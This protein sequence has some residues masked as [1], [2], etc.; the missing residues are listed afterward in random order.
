MK[1]NLVWF[2]TLFIATCS[3]DVFAQGTIIF[4]N[5]ITGA[6]VAPVYGPEPSGLPL[7]GNSPSGTPPGTTIYT[8]Q[9]LSG[10]GFTAQLWAGPDINSLEPTSPGKPFATGNG[11]GFYPNSTETVL[12]VPALGTAQLQ[13]RAWDNEGGNITSWNAAVAAG[14][15]HGE[16]TVF[17]SEPLGGLL[18]A[19]PN[20]VGLT[21]FSLG[22]NFIPEPSTW[23][24]GGLG[25]VLLVLLRRRD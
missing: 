18:G 9:L 5:H 10:T 7:Q 14:V 19:P 20:V 12:G 17:T 24:L 3:S 2:G 15:P 21:S 13:V 6:V 16:S 1:T 11:A 22:S 8:G 4:G 23:A 25:A